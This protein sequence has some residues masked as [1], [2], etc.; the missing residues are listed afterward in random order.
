M[1]IHTC[2]YVCMHAYIHAYTHTCMH[3]YIQAYMHT[4]IHSVRLRGMGTGISEAS[5]R[6][7]QAIFPLLPRPG[8]QASGFLF[9]TEELG[10]SPRGSDPVSYSLT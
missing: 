3:A 8:R 9:S 7:P 4:Y 10:P 2:I 6:V 5:K 1:H